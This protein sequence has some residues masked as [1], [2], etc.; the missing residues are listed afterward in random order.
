MLLIS[1]IK[2]KR[3]DFDGCPAQFCRNLLPPPAAG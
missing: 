3:V 2:I 1:Q